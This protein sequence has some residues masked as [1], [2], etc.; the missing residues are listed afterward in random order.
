MNGIQTDHVPS[1][2][3]SEQPKE[4]RTVLPHMNERFNRAGASARGPN[5]NLGMK[6]PVSS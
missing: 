5:R 4:D 1:K 6:S 2:D 3:R